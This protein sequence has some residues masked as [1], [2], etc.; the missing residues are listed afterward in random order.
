MKVG[1]F[2]LNKSNVFSGI[3]HGGI[4]GPILSTIYIDDLPNC[5]ASQCKIFADDMK[6][7]Y[8]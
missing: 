5:V 3:P 7:Y 8:K 4:L 2:Y 1:T 6:H